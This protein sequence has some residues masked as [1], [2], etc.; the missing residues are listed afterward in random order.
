M[1]VEGEEPLVRGSISDSFLMKTSNPH[2][3][4]HVTFTKV[5]AR[6]GSLYPPLSTRRSMLIYFLGEIRGRKVDKLHN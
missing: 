5:I 1:K 6:R 4:L 3:V 2:G